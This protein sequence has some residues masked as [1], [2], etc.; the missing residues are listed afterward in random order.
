MHANAPLSVLQIVPE[1]NAGGVERTTLDIAAAIVAAGGRS[2]VATQ[3]GRLAEE[4]EPSGSH[5][6][7][8]PYASKN[9]VT[10]WNNAGRL[11]K[12]IRAEKIGIVHARSRAPAWSARIAAQRTGAKFLTTYAGIY[13]ARSSMKRWYNSVMAKGDL[14]IANSAFTAQH[15]RD[16]YKNLRRPIAVIPRGIDLTKFDP[17]AVDPARVQALRREWGVPQSARIVLLPGR[18]TRWKGALSFIDAMSFIQHP[19]IFAVIAGDAQDRSEFEDEVIGRIAKHGLS[20]RLRYVGHVSDMAAA[21]AAADI[22]VSAS[23]EPEAFGRVAVE[24]QAMRK[25]VVATDL[26]AAKETVLPGETGWLVR[27]GD[28]PALALGIVE[29]LEIAPQSAAEIGAKARAHV[30]KRFDVHAMCAATLGVYRK[31]LAGNSAQAMAPGEANAG[32][33]G[34]FEPNLTSH[35]QV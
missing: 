22:V 27:A 26:G 3:G 32:H 21:Y 34:Q 19:N 28:A 11:A 1:L 24:G 35:S 29:A 9:P 5:L 14:V 7:E 18:L 16:T 12:I 15:I 25:L 17:K 30:M 6:I 23:L 4:L 31:V 20:E 33:S 8:G 13:N 2:F 10:I